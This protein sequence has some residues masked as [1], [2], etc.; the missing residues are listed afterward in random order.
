MK[1]KL[2]P[3]EVVEKVWDFVDQFI[4]PV[5]LIPKDDKRSP[6]GDHHGTGWFIE[7]NGDPQLCTCDHVARDQV[8]GILGYA[9]TG[10]DSGVSVESQFS[11]SPH[12]VDFAIANLSKTWELIS[13]T[14]KP[15]T[16]SFFDQKHQPVAG[17]YLYLQGFPGADSQPLFEQHNVKGLGAYLHEVEPPTEIF[18]EKPPFKASYHICMAWSPANA[19]PLTV[20]AGGLSVPGGLSGS[21]L[22]NTRYKEATEQGRQWTIN[23]MRVTGIVWG[24]SSK[25]GVVTATPVEHILKF[26]L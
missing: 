13:H 11:L 12:P 6:P 21:V 2:P 8:K 14:G 5:H 19:N 25:A 3:K 7:K 18:S 4:C 16:Q 17:E 9:P 20:A 1:N 26:I 24:A 22:W 10:C 23:D 15:I